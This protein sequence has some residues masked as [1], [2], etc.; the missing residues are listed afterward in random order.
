MF[1]LGWS[2]MAIIMLVAL[3]VIGPRDLPRVARTVGRWSAKGRS[4][5][6]EFQRSLDEMAREAELDDIK[7]E[8]DK[9]GRTDLRKTIERTID[10]DGRLKTAF[11]VKDKKLPK[12]AT[13]AE[14][15]KIADDGQSAGGTV[16]G[17]PGDADVATSAADR[18][19][20]FDPSDEL[21][22]KHPRADREPATTSTKS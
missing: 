6:R 2:E 11:E 4:L 21:G 17:Q 22:P 8:I 1:D 19:E 13:E 5:M 9:A 20:A 3:I 18:N 10:P 14:T 15:M 7:K 16:N 12:K